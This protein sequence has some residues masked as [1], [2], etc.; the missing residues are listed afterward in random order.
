MFVPAI[1]QGSSWKNGM[2]IKFVSS[3][4]KANGVLREKLKDW[5]KKSKLVVPS[6]Y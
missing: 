4:K 5:K 2:Q 3:Q 1:K 6:Y